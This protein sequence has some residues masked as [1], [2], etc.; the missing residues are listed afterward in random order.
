MKQAKAIWLSDLLV[1]V[2]TNGGHS[3]EIKKKI[4]VDLLQQII[5]VRYRRINWFHQEL[6][7]GENV[8]IYQ[9]SRHLQENLSN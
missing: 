8:C 4:L 1:P 2:N 6:G 3:P 5:I 9:F 7:S